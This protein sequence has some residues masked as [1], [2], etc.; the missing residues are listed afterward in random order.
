MQGDAELLASWRAG[1]SKAGRAL[2]ERYFDALSR[3]F[4]NKVDAEPEDFVQDVFAA[5]VRGS[6]RIREDA[7]FRSYLFSVAYN[8]L[9]EHYRRRYRHGIAEGLDSCSFEDLAPGPSTVVRGNDDQRMLLAALRRIPLELQIV[10]EMFYWEEMSSF[11]IATALDIPAG[12]AR[13]RLRRGREQLR[14]VLQELS[15]PTESEA[16][17]EDLEGWARRVRSSLL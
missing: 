9:R 11:E 1:D 8:R 5:C 14:R 3:F 2:F 15:T 12:T 17:P 16:V 7:N 6:S 13:S 10:L 4:L